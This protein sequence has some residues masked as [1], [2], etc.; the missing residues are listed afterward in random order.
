MYKTSN[1]AI[2]KNLPQDF[3]KIPTFDP[4]EI[5]WKFG[6][7]SPS[8]DTFG[9]MAQPD[10]PDTQQREDPAKAT[11]DP[12]KKPSSR[13]EAFAF[14]DAGM[15][16]FGFTSEHFDVKTED[17]YILD[18]FHITGKK[19]GAKLEKDK[20]P[21]MIQHAMG[22]CAEAWLAMYPNGTPMPL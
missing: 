15:E 2:A 7:G 21:I 17:G 4:E 13:D 12:Q 14:W 22:G 19:D 20:G 3:F 10:K 18:L 16:R 6:S 5:D 8:L 11:S 9:S 1:L